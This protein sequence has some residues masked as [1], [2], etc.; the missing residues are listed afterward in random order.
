LITMRDFAPY[1][2]VH[3]LYCYTIVGWWHPGD[4]PYVGLPPIALSEQSMAHAPWDCIIHAYSSG[5]SYNADLN[6]VNIDTP[7]TF[8]VEDTPC[9]DK[10][11][12]C[13]PLPLC[14]LFYSLYS[15]TRW[16]PSSV[17]YS[18]H[19]INICLLVIRFMVHGWLLCLNM[20]S[21]LMSGRNS[22]PSSD[23]PALTKL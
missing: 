16:C 20:V 22:L 3:I 17:H 15:Y 8:E 13:I 21:V 1:W 6:L 7:C 23:H 4:N 18:H 19:F 2:W 9:T 14:S 11:V 12:D 10:Q 5:Y